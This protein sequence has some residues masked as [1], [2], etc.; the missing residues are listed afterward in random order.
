MR[1]MKS[2]ILIGGLVIS[3]ILNAFAAHAVC[4]PNP[5]FGLNFDDQEAT[6]QV[7]SLAMSKIYGADTGMVRL[8]AFWMG[9]EVTQN[10][11][12]WTYLDSRVNAARAAGLQ[13]LLTF[14]GIPRWA[15]GASP[16]CD[17]WA[18]QCSAPPTNASFF[19]D[20]A[21][22]VASRYRDSIDYYEIWN[23]PDYTV[24]WG[25]NMSDFHALIAQPGATAIR[26]AD[27][28]AVILGPAMLSSKTKLQNFL[29]LACSYIDIVTVHAYEGTAAGMKN[30]VANK[31]TS[32]MS[33][34]GCPKQLWVTEFG[35]KSNVVGEAAQA[36][37]Y[38]WA[39]SDLLAGRLKAARL[40]YY[41]LEDPGPSL[42]SWGVTRQAPTY[43]EKPSYFRVRDTIPQI[44]N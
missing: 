31:W 30:S 35:V 38:G 28:G 8:V 40:F 3:G 2:A 5:K 33:S 37:E 39:A 32:A 27:P 21:A 22:D 23:E 12:N 1:R 15:N 24:F 4:T 26:A 20:F 29:S 43:V 17:F 11:I 18:G 13:I 34:V 9:M 19:A 25:S 10:Q 7:V 6:P 16:S 44:C 42:P 36:N 41:R 14:Y